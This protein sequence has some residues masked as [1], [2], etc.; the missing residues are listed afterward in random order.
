MAKV[1][2][3]VKATALGDKAKDLGAGIGLVIVS[4]VAL[5]TLRAQDV[6]FGNAWP[7]LDPQ[8]REHVMRYA[9]DFKAF[10]GKAKSEMQFV[11]QAVRFAESNGFR[12]WDPR[13]AAGLKPGS[14]WYAARRDRRATL[15]NR[16]GAGDPAREVRHYGTRSAERGHPDCPSHGAP[17]CRPRSRAGR[18]LRTGRS[19]DGLHQP[20][21]ELWHL[22]RGFVAFFNQ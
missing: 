9:D 12:K 2:S 4:L 5:T 18:R 19:I 21:G 15:G 16:S 10:L 17:R 11:R 1:R 20:A 6:G 7:E 13:A 14:R 22:H 3:K 8:S